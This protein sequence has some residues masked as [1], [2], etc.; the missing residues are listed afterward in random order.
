MSNGGH[1]L[2]VY[3]RWLE[4]RHGGQ[5]CTGNVNAVEGSG[6]SG[7]RESSLQNGEMHALW[8]WLCLVVAKMPKAGI[9]SS[10]RASID[11]KTMCRPASVSTRQLNTV[12]SRRRS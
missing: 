2:S 1:L 7:R 12:P 9:N 5:M 8:L 3:S 10:M 4:G 11:L 6:K